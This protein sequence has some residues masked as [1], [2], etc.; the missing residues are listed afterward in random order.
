ML[1]ARLEASDGRLQVSH[2]GLVS[3]DG[4]SGAWVA[5]RTDPATGKPSDL[6]FDLVVL[7][8]ATGAILDHV[9]WGAIG[10]GWRHIMGFV[11]GLHFSLTLGETGSM[12]LGICA[13]VWTLDCFVGFYLTLPARRSLP[14]ASILSPSPL[15]PVPLPGDGSKTWEI[16]QLNMVGD[17]DSE[18]FMSL[19][20][21]SIING[22]EVANI[23]GKQCPFL[24]DRIGKLL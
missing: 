9:S 19:S 2:L 10:Q 6:G 22:Q 5:P 3:W 17:N 15:A 23:V 16:S 14:P 12:I 8:P 24:T 20:A 21:V 13:L 4:A 7:D 1:A 11:Y 18:V